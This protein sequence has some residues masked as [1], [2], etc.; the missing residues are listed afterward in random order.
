MTKN[1]LPAWV[2]LCLLIAGFPSR[3]GEEERLSFPAAGGRGE[4]TEYQLDRGRVPDLSLLQQV[5][6][7]RLAQELMEL[8]ARQFGGFNGNHI[9]ERF[10]LGM[11]LVGTGGDQADTNLETVSMPGMATVARSMLASMLESWRYR[12]VR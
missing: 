4:A 9:K 2:A 11:L 12:R 8:T 3:A 10:G 1:P 7:E 6:P 5:D